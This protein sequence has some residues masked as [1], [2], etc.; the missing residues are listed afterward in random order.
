MN[1]LSYNKIRFTKFA[2]IK[3]SVT[4]HHNQIIVFIVTYL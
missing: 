3:V 2:A 1:K 4:E